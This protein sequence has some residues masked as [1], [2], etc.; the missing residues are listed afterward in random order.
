[1]SS[2]EEIASIRESFDQVSSTES[3]ISLHVL[4]CASLVDL[5]WSD[6]ALKQQ[7]SRDWLANLRAL[8][9]LLGCPQNERRG[10]DIWLHFNILEVYH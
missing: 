1:M 7:Y 3:T 6:R 5:A 8:I 10:G 4:C 2:P 9:R